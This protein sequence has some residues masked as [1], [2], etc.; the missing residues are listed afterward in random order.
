MSEAS[1]LTRMGQSRAQAVTA[2]RR[3]DRKALAELVTSK[4]LAYRATTIYG[5][6]VASLRAL[7]DDEVRPRLTD[8]CDPRVV[9]VD[10]WEDG[11]PTV[12]ALVQALHAQL[13]LGDV[14]D[15]GPPARALEDAIA[16]A[17]RRSERPIVLVLFGVDRIDAGR[18]PAEER[19]FVDALAHLVAAPVRGLSLLM[20]IEEANLGIFRE[21][22][23]GRW[24]LLVHDVRVP[25]GEGL[26]LAPLPLVGG[27]TTIATA[28]AGVGAAAAG[29]GAAAAVTMTTGARGLA[30]A[31][32]GLLGLV[33]L[34]VG[35]HGLQRAEAAEAALATCQE[36][37]AAAEACPEADAGGV[38]LIPA[39]APPDPPGAAAA[40]HEP[41]AAIT[42]EPD[43]VATTGEAP[44]SP[45]T[46]SDTD[47]V[48]PASEAPASS[49]KSPGLCDAHGGDGPCGACVRASCC[50]QLRA[51]KSRK[52]QRCVLTGAVGAGECT[53]AAIE[54]GCRGLALCALEYAC[55]EACFAP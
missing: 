5:R 23:R 46:S 32:A 36:A 31:L 15:L 38:R 27:G 21:L 34:G 43:E 30:L 25:E 12:K 20:A 7:V 24:R 47:E 51:C 53:P 55:H 4:L 28:T 40:T 41:A 6:S 37:L 13:D 52:W 48:A 35:A 26:G 39:E 19:R 42:S 10:A 50:D 14:D 44:A 29:G 17:L 11:G 33:G 49:S 9:V 18:D 2:Y 3:R 1:I 8:A 16:R 45:G 22:L 54:K